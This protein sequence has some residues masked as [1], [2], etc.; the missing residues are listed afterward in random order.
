MSTTELR[1]LY[2]EVI[3]DHSKRPR[4]FREIASATSRADGFN[5]LCGD[6]A[7]VFVQLEGDEKDR[8]SLVTL[9]CCPV[10]RG[11]L[12]PGDAAREEIVEGTG[13]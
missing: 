7:T 10:C 13:L 8:A 4:N 12:S 9:L 1:E 6:K 11:P 3:L 2:Q 5:P